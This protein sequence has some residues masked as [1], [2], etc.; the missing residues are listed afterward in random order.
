VPYEEPTGDQRAGLAHYKRPPSAFENFVKEEGIPVYKGIGVRDSRELPLGPWKRL[1]GRGSYIQLSG[2]QGLT[3]LYVVEVPAAGALNPERHMYEERFIV[4]EGRGTTEVWNEG[5]S[6]RQ[7]FEWQPG[8]VFSAPL[9]AWHRAVNAT[10]SPALLLAVTT[11]PIIVNLFQNRT[12]VFDNPFEFSERF[13]ERSDFFNPN[14]E[15]EPDPIQKR[16]MLRT[17]IIPDAVNCYLPLDNWR[18]PGYRWILPNMVGNT[19]LRGFIAEYPSG[20]YSKAHFHPSGPVLVCLRGKGYSVTW[21]K[22]LGVQPWAAGKGEQVIQQ[23]YVPGGMVSAAPGGGDWLHQ[24]FAIGKDPFR[25]FNFTGGAGIG[26]GDEGDEIVGGG[27]NIQQG[28]TAVG[29]ADEDPY[30]RKYYQQRLAEEEVKF[31]MP[32]EVYSR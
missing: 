22:E 23:D 18:G 11:A 17:N 19:M 24:H 15:F 31:Q 9:N 13:Q 8:S 30:I 16:A 26:G 6:R 4:L 10:S 1:G 32:A 12:F 2:T 21:P 7:A 5:S 3:S 28:G 20:R 29:Y 14:E 27:A 25:V